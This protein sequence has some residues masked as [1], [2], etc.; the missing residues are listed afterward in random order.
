MKDNIQAIFDDDFI[1]FLQN[2]GAKEII[3]RGEA[4]CKFCKRVLGIDDVATVFAEGGTLKFVCD[5]A[6][7]ICHMNN[8]FNDK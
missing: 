7:C 3:D 6:S 8:Y 5:D 2:I 1:A 4:K